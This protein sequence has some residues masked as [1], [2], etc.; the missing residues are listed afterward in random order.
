MFWS[1]TLGNFEQY[2]VKTMKRPGQNH[3]QQYLVKLE[4]KLGKDTFICVNYYL[5]DSLT[6]L[7]RKNIKQNDW[8]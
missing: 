5:A 7:I 3:S 6:E 8:F 4:E 1:E 2:F